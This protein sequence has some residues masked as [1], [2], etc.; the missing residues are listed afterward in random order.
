[1]GNAE[2]EANYTR[3]RAEAE[4]EA[5]RIR[6][7]ATVAEAEAAAKGTKIR[8]EASI[9]EAEAQAE[10]IRVKAQAEAERAKVV[11][12]TPLGEKLALLDVYS[13]A[14]KSANEGVEKVVY[15]DPATTA[16]SNP[17]ALLTLQSL[18]RELQGVANAHEGLTTKGH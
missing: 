8:A 15:M 4:A 18:T 1:M 12:E 2:A 5:T 10:G 9:A 13:S 16:G 3:V 14:V 17:F 6:A 11:G 7:E